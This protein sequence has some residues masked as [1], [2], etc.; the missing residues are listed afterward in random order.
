[1]WLH[2]RYCKNQEKGENEGYNRG[3]CVSVSVL[4]TRQA[5]TFK[6]VLI[7]IFVRELGFLKL[8]W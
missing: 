2:W 1:M 7:F 3:E 8:V 5:K 6:I 4:C